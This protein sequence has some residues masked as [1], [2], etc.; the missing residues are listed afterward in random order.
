MKA[1][2]ILEAHGNSKIYDKCWDG[3][4]KV[5]GKKRGEK[6]SCVKEDATAGATSAGNIAAVASVPGAKRKVSKKGKYGA[7]TAPQATNADGTAKNALDLNTNVMGG[8]AIK[9]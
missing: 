9:R 1:F 8:K 5:R 3:Y 7:P 4:K 2:E 6:G